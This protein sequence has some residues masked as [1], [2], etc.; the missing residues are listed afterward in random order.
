MFQSIF[1]ESTLSPRD[2]RSHFSSRKTNEGLLTCSRIN[3]HVQ[4][5]NGITSV[6]KYEPCPGPGIVQLPKH[7][8]SD[9]HDGIVENGKA[10]Y[11]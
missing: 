2:Q 1:F 3:N 10:N 4:N 7:T 9:D 8:S 6:I 5:V 11:E